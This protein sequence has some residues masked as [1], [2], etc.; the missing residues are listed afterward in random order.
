[1]YAMTAAHPTL[2]I[3]SYARIR[4][5]ANGREVLVRVNDRGPVRHRPHR[6]PELCR[7]VQARPAARR[8][9]GRARADHLRRDPRRRL[10]RR[11]REPRCRRRR[12]RAAGGERSRRSPL[13]VDVPVQ[14]VAFTPTVV[15][16]E[17]VPP[18][19]AD[20][21]APAAWRLPARRRRQRGDAR[22]HRRRQRD[23]SWHPRRQPTAPRFAAVASADPRPRLGRAP[24]EAARGFWVQL[25]A[26]RERDGAESFRRRVAA[27][28][29]ST[30][31]RAVA[32]DFRR[33]GAL[34]RPGR[35]VSE[36]RRGR[37]PPR[38]A[39]APR[40]ASSRSSSSGDER[41]LRRS[42][43]RARRDGHPSAGRTRRTRR[44][45]R[46]SSPATWSTRPVARAALPRRRAST[47]AA[48]RI[49][50]RARRDRRRCPTT[51]R[52]PRAPP[53]AT[54]CSP[55][56]VSRARVPLRLLLPLAEAE[57]V[58]A[59]AAAGR[60]R[61]RV[62][63]ALSRRRRP[64]RRAAA[65]GAGRRSAR[66]P[67]GADAFVRANLWLLDTRARLRRRRRWSASACGTAAA[68]TGRAARAISSRRCAPRA[69]ASLRIDTRARFERA[70]RS[71]L[72]GLRRRATAMLQSSRGVPR[73][74][75]SA[76][77]TMIRP[78]RRADGDQHIRGETAWPRQRAKTKGKANG[79]A[80]DGQGDGPVASHRP[81]HRQR[82]RLRRLDRPARRLRVRRQRHGG[83]RQAAGHASR[84]R[85]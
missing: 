82:R 14:D 68:A 24:A 15:A 73:L 18:V 30:L 47:Q 85:C 33:R 34:P 26:F 5:P 61:R 64:A 40:S 72:R 45:R 70:R 56:R 39:R 80:N 10:A 77:A 55:R 48:R 32:R 42:A 54:C 53:A 13:A 3:P 2:P 43:D 29:E 83:D 21:P 19:A 84:R 75:R 16:V 57:F 27:D 62:A 22:L 44:A 78:Q 28:G 79:D 8:R 66:W 60:R 6:R 52:S 31:A 67:P 81:E 23:D 74:R 38:S 58:A 76:R 12:D 63:R 51:S 7:G 37:A 9:A 20:R 1:M 65:R 25:G 35:P 4:N 41:P 36:P 50:G 46:S 11:R 17:A 69:A 71:T 49:D 59:L